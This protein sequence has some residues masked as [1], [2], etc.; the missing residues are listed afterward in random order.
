MARFDL[1]SGTAKPANSRPI[2]RAGKRPNPAQRTVAALKAVGARAMSA[3]QKPE[4]AEEGWE[5]F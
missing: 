1:G 5:E 4:P 3:V 2:N